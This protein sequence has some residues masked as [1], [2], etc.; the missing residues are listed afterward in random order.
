MVI[1]GKHLPSLLHLYGGAQYVV[2]DAQ[3]PA[4]VKPEASAAFTIIMPQDY[5]GRYLSLTPY[6]IIIAYLRT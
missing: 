6:L 4:F 1:P 2:R 5:Q 3:L